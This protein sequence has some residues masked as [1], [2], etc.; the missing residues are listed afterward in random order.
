[1]P[2]W[3]VHLITK[4]QNRRAT[5]PNQ[6]RDNE[7]HVT[8]CSLVEQRDN[9]PHHPEKCNCV[10]TD[11]MSPR[12]QQRWKKEC[13]WSTDFWQHRLLETVVDANSH[14]QSYQKRNILFYFRYQRRW[15]PFI[16]TWPPYTSFVRIKPMYMRANQA[17]NFYPSYCIR[18]QLAPYSFDCHPYLLHFILSLFSYPQLPDFWFEKKMNALILLPFYDITNIELFNILETSDE[19]IK[20]KLEN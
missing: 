12:T 15:R 14:K 2:G 17:R 9:K 6:R 18:S 16:G 3:P 7:I 13:T 8:C 4:P 5:T 1:M 19:V 11:N 20:E 10:Y